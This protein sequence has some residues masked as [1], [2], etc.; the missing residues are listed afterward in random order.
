MLMRFYYP[1]KPTRITVDSDIFKECDRNPFF[2]LQIKKNGW[3][4]QIHKN[5]DNVE[6]YTRH[7]RRMEPIV[8]E[9]DWKLLTDLVRNNIKAETA[10]IDGEFLHRR[11]ETKNTIYM[12]DI[13]EHDKQVVKKPYGERKQLLTSITTQTSNLQISQDIPSGEFKQIWDNL[14]NPK[15]NEGIVIKDIREPLYIVYRKPSKNTSPRQFKV[16]LDDKRN[17][18]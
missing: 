13:F 1:T 15:E 16:L 4:I 12:W 2:I 14:R 3:R 7:N 5:G 11:G 18:V 6:F 10:I 17:E 9:A 8:A